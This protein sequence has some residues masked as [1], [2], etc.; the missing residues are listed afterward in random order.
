MRTRFSPPQKPSHYTD[1]VLAGSSG[2]LPR[3]G[4]NP[5]GSP[6]KNTDGNSPS[7]EGRARLLT[8]LEV[9]DFLA[10]SPRT[11]RRLITRRSIPCFRIGRSVRF[12]PQAVSRWL[13]ARQEGG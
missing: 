9:A 7:V 12:S 13:E 6:D 2:E 8:L 5:L 4:A 10:V 3:H 1:G 11:V